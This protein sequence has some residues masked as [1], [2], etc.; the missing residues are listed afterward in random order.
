MRISGYYYKNN[1]KRNSIYLWIAAIWQERRIV[2]ITL[3]ECYSRGNNKIV[4][5]DSI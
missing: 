3:L 5:D 4:M 2:A 1:I